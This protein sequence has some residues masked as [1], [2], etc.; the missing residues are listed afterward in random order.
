MAQPNL[1]RRDFLVRSGAA[2]MALGSLSM[3][4]ARAQ[5]ANDRLSIGIIG[6]GG[7]GAGALMPEV[8]SQGKDLNVEI[9]AICDVWRPAREKAVAQVKEWYGREPRAFSRYQELL[10]L[11]DVDAV[12]IA[13]PDFA[14]SPILAAAAKAGKD[15][16]CEKPMATKLKDAKAAVDAV[17]ANQR[18][19]QIG[20]QRRSDG[21]HKGGAALIQSGVLGAISEVEAA[22]HDAGPRWAR[23]YGDVKQEDVD[24][25]GYLMDLPKRPF[26]P[27][28]YRRWHLY[29]D[30]TVGTPG[31]LGSHMMD[32]AVWFMDDLLP[33]TGTA[34]GGIFVWRDGREHADTLRCL[35]TYPKGWLLNYCTRLGNTKAPADV[36]FYALKGTFDTTSWTAVG[37]GGGREKLTQPVKAEAQPGENHMRNWLECIRSRQQPNA[38]V[39]AGYAHSVASIMCFQAFETGR[40]QLYDAEKREIRPA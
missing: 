6:C 23:G 11:D 3:P 26:D 28:R 20:T 40:T 22:F 15:A 21:R 36:V 4:S 19:V 14:H 30:Y 38:P 16:Y 9:T 13:T 1:T 37:D 7:R 29:K 17:V 10:A 18:V 27:A 24:W 32:V 31:L 34:N 39:Q 12:T 8:Y 33:L 2:A 25:Q 35:L 5:G